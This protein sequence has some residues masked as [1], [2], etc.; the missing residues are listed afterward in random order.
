MTT[1][2]RCSSEAVRRQL[3]GQYRLG[4]LGEQGLARMTDRQQP[5]AATERR[6]EVVALSEL[7]L[8]SGRAT[9]TFSSRPSGQDSPAKLFWISSAY[10]AAAAA[11]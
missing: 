4:G 11:V 2:F 1:A 5:G 6:T 10:S 3:I 9:L 7:R 8:S